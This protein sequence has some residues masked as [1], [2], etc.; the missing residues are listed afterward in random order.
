MT[1]AAWT[2]LAL[3]LAHLRAKLLEHARN[4]NRAVHRER[5]TGVD[6]A[7]RVIC[8]TLRKRAKRFDGRR[9]MRIV[10][11]QSK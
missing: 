3:A 9:F 11:G 1:R 2:D 4:E 8:T 5:V 10:A 6:L 7:A